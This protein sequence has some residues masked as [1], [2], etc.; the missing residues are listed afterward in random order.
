MG[1]KLTLTLKA[2][3]Y[4]VFILK[5]RRSYEG[6]SAQKAE[7]LYGYKIKIKLSSLSSILEHKYL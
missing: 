6:L 4:E 2:A 5:K 1:I 7:W 3:K